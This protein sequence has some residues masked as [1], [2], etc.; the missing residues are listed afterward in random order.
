MP[1]VAPAGEDAD[2][3]KAPPSLLLPL[4]QRWAGEPFTG[5]P[6]PHV[7]GPERAPRS[8]RSAGAPDRCSWRV[9]RQRP[10]C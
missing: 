9:T 3:T 2:L 5:R 7:L 1:P 4:G 10:M 6:S 8:P